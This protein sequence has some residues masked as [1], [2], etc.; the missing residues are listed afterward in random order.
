MCLILEGYG[1]QEFR[2]KVMTAGDYGI[3]QSFSKALKSNMADSNRRL[4]I[5]V[6]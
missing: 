2:L 1:D 4:I 3:G 6:G 5:L